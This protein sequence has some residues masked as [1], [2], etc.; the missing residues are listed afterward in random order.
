[1]GESKIRGD[2]KLRGGKGHKRQ[3]Y[4]GDTLL[5]DNKG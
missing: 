2:K 5:K 1:M 4:W 3:F